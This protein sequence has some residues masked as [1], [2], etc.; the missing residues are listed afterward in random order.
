MIPASLSEFIV[1]KPKAGWRDWGPGTADRVVVLRFED[2]DAMAAA[3]VAAGIELPGEADFSCGLGDVSIIGAVVDGEIVTPAT[4]LD[5]Y[6]VNVLPPEPDAS[7]EPSPPTPL[8][9][10][11]FQRAIERHV[12]AVAAERSYS[13]A[14]SLASY[15]ASTNPLWQA[16]AEAFVAWRDAVW[17][18]A[19]TELAKV[20]AQER[21]VPESTAAFVAELPVIAWPEA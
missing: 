8:T 20:Q 3:F 19:L 13:S 9:A 17:V 5:G 2:R 11:Q 18:Y 15:V 21:A 16:E 6:F 14:V 1:E 12:D 7:G 10:E 4:F